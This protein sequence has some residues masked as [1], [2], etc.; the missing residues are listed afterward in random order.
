MKRKTSSR[1]R[2]NRS[3]IPLAEKAQTINIK[4]LERNALSVERCE[5]IATEALDGEER[6]SKRATSSS[7]LM[8]M[9][10][11]T[12]GKTKAE[13]SNYDSS[14][15]SKENDSYNLNPRLPRPVGLRNPKRDKVGKS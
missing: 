8:R 15:E 7:R 12:S 9:L 10:G 13:R 1:R 6:L 5:S 2:C 3:M 4:I 14:I 11:F